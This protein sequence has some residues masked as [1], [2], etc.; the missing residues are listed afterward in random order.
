M[1]SNNIRLTF[2]IFQKYMRQILKHF[3][4][5]FFQAYISCI[6]KECVSVF[7][8]DATT[9]LNSL[10]FFDINAWMIWVFTLIRGLCCVLS[11]TNYTYNY[12]IHS[13]RIINMVGKSV[14]VYLSS[15]TCLFFL[16]VAKK[17]KKIIVGI[18]IIV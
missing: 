12:I 14:L 10:W 11:Y 13:S 15:T 18:Y 1:Y 3:T 8:D 6:S 4:R 5:T 16:S 7:D 17:Q 9:N 2:F